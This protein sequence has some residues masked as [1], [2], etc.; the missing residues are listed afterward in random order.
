MNTQDNNIICIS[1]ILPIFI[2]GLNLIRVI[3]EIII[4]KLSSSSSS[5]SI[6]NYFIQKSK[7]FFE[8]INRVD[9]C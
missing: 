8:E 7:G 4:Y 2:L 3:G 5:L 1:N 9:N 6:T